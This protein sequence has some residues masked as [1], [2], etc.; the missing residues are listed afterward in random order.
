[1]LSKPGDGEVIGQHS[2]RGETYLIL[3]PM[4]VSNSDHGAI[5]VEGVRWRSRRPN[6]GWVVIAGDSGWW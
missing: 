6:L 2:A 5:V 4:V 3:A 1:M